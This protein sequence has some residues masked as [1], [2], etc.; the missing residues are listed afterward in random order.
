MFYTH[1]CIQV[2]KTT[3]TAWKT[4]LKQGPGRF[5]EKKINSFREEISEAHSTYQV[6]YLSKSLIRTK[7]MLT[8]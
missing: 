3:D 8:I 1:V 2:Y 6:S 7:H 5:D 4:D